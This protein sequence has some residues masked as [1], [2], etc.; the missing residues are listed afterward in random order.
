[1]TNTTS[2]KAILFDKDGT[3]LDF[4]ASWAGINEALAQMAS[5]GNPQFTDKLLRIAGMDPLSK[6]TSAGS[7]FAA[8]NSQEIAEAWIS[9]GAKFDQAQLASEI[10]KLCIEGMRSAV[11]LPGIPGALHALSK[12]GFK[13]GVASSDSEASIHAFLQATGLSGHFEFIVGYDSGHGPK[14]EPGMMTGF[15][16]AIDLPV[17][18]IAMIG[19]NTHD[20]IMAQA[21]SAGLKIGVLSGTGTEGDLSPLADIILESVAGLPDFLDNV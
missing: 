14:P 6:S 17:S 18:A 20:L 15:A 8:G 13:L 11:P 19:D 7:L 12:A 2:I 5:D 9:A 21:A 1:M 3:L 10:D 4:D 16:A